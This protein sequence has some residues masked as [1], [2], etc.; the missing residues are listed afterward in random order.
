LLA[1]ARERFSLRA[2]ALMEPK[3]TTRR[4]SEMSLMRSINSQFVVDNNFAL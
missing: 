2:A 1:T 4:K 3:S